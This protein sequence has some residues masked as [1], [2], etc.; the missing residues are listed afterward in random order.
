MPKE[1]LLRQAL[2]W[3]VAGLFCLPT[4]PSAEP[5]GATD[6][7]SGVTVTAATRT[8]EPL[9]E[10][11]AAVEVITGE[12]MRQSGA[13]ML[14]EALRAESSIYMGPDGNA[15]SIRGGSK[16]DMIYLVDGRR[17]RGNSG[18]SFEL[19]RL[20]VSQIERVEIVKGP[21]SV[22]YGSDAVAGVIN[23]ITRKPGAGLEASVEAQGVRPTDAEGGDRDSAA[24]FLG[25]GSRDTRFRLMADV[26]ARDAYSEEA[27]AAVSPKKAT[28][29]LPETYRFDEDLR[30][31]ADVYNVRGSLSHRV[32][33]VFRVALDAGLTQ[34]VRDWRSV[35]A[36]P[37]VKTGYTDDN[38]KPIRASQIPS[39]QEEEVTRRD[40]AATAEWL[41]TDT[42][43]L[44]YRLYQSR[45]RLER[46][47]TFLDP[48]AFGFASAEA[49]DFGAREVTL[50]DRVNDLHAT[51]T[52]SPGQTVLAG[53]EHNRQ[54]YRDHLLAG[55]AK[56][57]Q[58]VAGVYAQHQWQATDR[59]KLV[60]GARYD[61]SSGDVDNT[62]LQAGAV[63][64]LRRGLRLRARYAE[65]FKVPELRS[66]YVR[67]QNPK[68][69]PV[70]GAYVTDDGLGKGRHAL[71][72]QRSRN[73][74]IGVKGRLPLGS[75]AVFQ[76][77]LGLFY[78]EFDDRITK[79]WAPS[80]QY[81]TFRNVNDA[82]TQGVETALG[83]H[84][85]TVE[86][87]VAATWLDAIDRDTHNTL[88]DAPPLTAV[89][90]VAWTPVAPLRLEVRVRYVGERYQDSAN[91]AKDEAYTLTGVDVGYQPARW[92]GL[93]LRAGVEN[94]LDADND[95]SLVPDPGRRVQAGVRYD[96]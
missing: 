92:P 90:S 74:E 50:T 24:F 80:K 65:G 18:R 73:Y 27:V 71:D 15:F 53:F 76:Y 49:S 66:Y 30:E 29:Q 88:P 35:H 11:T 14:D 64:Q 69:D 78:T 7:L 68:G 39:R 83:L 89:G 45:Y 46:A 23:V 57:A 1:P 3:S 33:E 75:T 12:E 81:M 54:S 22:V 21:G 4:T 13:S 6:T 56:D 55:E 32:T 28:D 87:K 5:S 47:K 61:D 26:M 2:T 96:F 70:L 94:L 86:W 34:E 77:D 62:S 72:P 91:T 9:E 19:N 51:W 52:P 43:N 10:T 8:P 82:R 42:L 36:S 93:T 17:I 63:Y 16:Q 60:Y 95:T 44:R 37:P 20:P 25:G 79:T 85:P 41:A 38:G 67:A 84:F 48:E 40:L 58:W 31:E 59:L